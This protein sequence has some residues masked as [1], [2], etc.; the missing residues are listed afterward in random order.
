[1]SDPL[2]KKILTQVNLYAKMY[3]SK[4]YVTFKKNF[5]IW[6]LCL[7]RDPDRNQLDSF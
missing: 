6:V 3:S 5:K 1:M 2:I 4:L 7:N